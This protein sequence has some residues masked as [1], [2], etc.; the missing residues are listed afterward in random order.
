MPEIFRPG[1]SLSLS[2]S[3][4]MLFQS[5]SLPDSL[6]LLLVYLSIYTFVLSSI[7]LYLHSSS[8][9]CTSAYISCFLYLPTYLPTYL[10][11]PTY[12]LPTCISIYLAVRLCI[13]S[14]LWGMF[15]LSSSSPKP[16]ITFPH[17]FLFRNQLKHLS[18]SR[19]LLIIRMY[20]ENRI[21]ILIIWSLNDQ[22]FV[23]NKTISPFYIPQYGG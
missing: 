16:F 8:V 12:Q 6:H 19:E 1:T 21:F 11:P 15:F 2:L 17:S 9:L 4:V 22:G 5:C 14:L 23:R 3:I 13:P 7:L 20:F 18:L 10:L